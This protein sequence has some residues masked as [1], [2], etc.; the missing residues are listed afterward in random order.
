[1]KNRFVIPIFSSIFIIVMIIYVAN[2]YH[3]AKELHGYVIAD[4]LID[5]SGGF[6]R[7]G[8]SGSMSLALCD[9]FDIL[10]NFIVT[11]IQIIFYLA[12][13][14]LFF[15]LI[16]RKKLDAWSL[17]LILSPV[18]LMFPIIDVCAVGRKEIILFTIFGAYLMCLRKDLLKSNLIIC[19][20]SISLLL[21]TFFH[22]LIFF[23][24]PYFLLAA[25]IHSATGGSSVRWSRP[26]LVISGS[27]LAILP[28][29]FFGKSIDG[30]VICQ[31]LMDR[32]LDSRIC[33]G[34]LTGPIEY[35]VG[36]VFYQVNTAN[37]F[38]SYGLAL[39][40]GLIPFVLFVHYQNSAVITVKRFLLTFPFL[41]LFSSPLF[42]LAF[43]W[44]RWI[45][46]H[47]IMLLFT[48]TLLLK[49]RSKT[50]DGWLKERLP[51]PALWKY[52]D[53]GISKRINNAVFLILCICY[54]S[55]WQMRHFGE[56][57]LFYLEKFQGFSAEISKTIAIADELYILTVYGD[58]F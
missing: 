45:N 17:I 2:L 33:A 55:F 19:L 9:L 11:I 32:G 41:F 5:F 15:L 38:S 7:R 48:C 20:F 36:Y 3:C 4:W 23:Y 25:F 56:F 24:T 12:Y 35:S 53:N 57:Q 30:P 44:G 29:Y 54:L 58:S 22:E 10:P 46:I 47:F 14:L 1:M 40:L 42:A 16:R 37:Y 51:I 50:E 8:L 28:L 43:D 27:L 34:I 13:M 49:E 26:L 21:A 39:L 52:P 6:V 18:T 31:E